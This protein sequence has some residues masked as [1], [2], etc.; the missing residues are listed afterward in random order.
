M[1]I[2]E[3]LQQIK[4]AEYT[5]SGYCLSLTDEQFFSQPEGKWS[6]ARQVKHL[7]IAAN[8]TK[9]VFVL[10]KFIVRWY[11]GKP[12]R[13]SRSYDELVAR[14]K[15]KLMQGGKQAAGLF[16]NQYFPATANKICLINLKD[17]WTT[18]W[19]Q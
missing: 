11:A 12:N 5:F 8:N 19:L 18:W 3:I 13:P 15:S 10:P 9:L 14:Y 1:T 4:M 6:P 2:D 17:Q 7:V 16:P